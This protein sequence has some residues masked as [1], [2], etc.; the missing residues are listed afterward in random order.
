MAP[1]TGEHIDIECPTQQR[2][3]VEARRR[4]EHRPPSRRSARRTEMPCGVAP[5]GPVPE[6]RPFSLVPEHARGGADCDGPCRRGRPRETRG[7]EMS[8]STPPRPRFPPGGPSWSE[9]Q[10]LQ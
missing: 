4:R 6:D 3:P 1:R 2:R 5:A 9:P 8:R 10:L 7:G